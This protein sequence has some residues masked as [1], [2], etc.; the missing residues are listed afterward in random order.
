MFWREGNVDKYHIFNGTHIRL[1][2]F[3]K[4]KA[5]E[6]HKK[7][8]DC[9]LQYEFIMHVS[10]IISAAAFYILIL[11]LFIVFVCF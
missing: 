2:T 10:C 6:S 7:N 11:S 4:S 1:N 5:V 8:M 9:V 3:V